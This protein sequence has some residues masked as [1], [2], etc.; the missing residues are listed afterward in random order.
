MVI[1]HA[2]EGVDF[3]N[4]IPLKKKYICIQGFITRLFSLKMK[5]YHLQI[6]NAQVKLRIYFPLK[7]LTKSILI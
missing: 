6:W 4:H 5:I 7:N 1:V 3:K 2:S